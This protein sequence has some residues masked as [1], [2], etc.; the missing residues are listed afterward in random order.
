MW[1]NMEASRLLPSADVSFLMPRWPNKSTDTVEYDCCQQ[2]HP[3][4]RQIST[5]CQPGQCNCIAI[6]YLLCC[7]L[8]SA[9]GSPNRAALGN[10]IGANQQRQEPL[11]GTKTKM[12]PGITSAKSGDFC[13][14]YKNKWNHQNPCFPNPHNDLHVA[15]KPTPNNQ[16]R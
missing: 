13:F 12:C 9:G 15:L 8:G 11:H 4:H 3:P 16:K 2:S 1:C 10:T 14:V 5:G 6:S 7:C